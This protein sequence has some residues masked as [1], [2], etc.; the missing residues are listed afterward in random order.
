MRAQKAEVEKAEAEVRKTLAEAILAEEKAR[1]ENIK[2][3][4]EDDLVD[5]QAA[6]AATA[7]RKTRVAEAQVAVAADRNQVERQKAATK[8]DGNK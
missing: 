2:A 3:D 4:L 8:S 5:I 6:N 7:A 1:H